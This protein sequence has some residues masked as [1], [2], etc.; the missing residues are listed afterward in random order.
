MFGSVVPRVPQCY[1]RCNIS[2]GKGSRP[3]STPIVFVSLEPRLKSSLSDY[4][5][6]FKETDREREREKR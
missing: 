6:F 2:G 1:L 5:F 4:C 3:S